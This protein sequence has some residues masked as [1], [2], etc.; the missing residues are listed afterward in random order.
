MI[1][2]ET[3]VDEIVESLKDNLNNDQYKDHTLMLY[4]IVKNL[5]LMKRIHKRKNFGRISVKFSNNITSKHNTL[6]MESISIT[7]NRGDLV[8]LVDNIPIKITQNE[9]NETMKLISL[10]YK[11][12]TKNFTLPYVKSLSIAIRYHDQM[13]NN[14]ELGILFSMFDFS[15]GHSLYNDDISF[16][17]LIF[18]DNS[19]GIGLHSILISKFKLINEPNYI[20]KLIE[21]I[22]SVI[23]HN[24]L[25]NYE[26]FLLCLCQLN[27]KCIEG[28]F[29]HYGKNIESSYNKILSLFRDHSFMKDQVKSI[30]SIVYINMILVNRCEEY[31]N[32]LMKINPSQYNLVLFMNRYLTVG[33][34]KFNEE[35]GIKDKVL[36]I[37]KLIKL[38]DMYGSYFNGDFSNYEKYIKTKCNVLGYSGDI[39]SHCYKLHNKATRIKISRIRNFKNKFGDLGD[40]DINDIRLCPYVISFRTGD[41]DEFQGYN[42]E[43]V[44]DLLEVFGK[45]N[46]DIPL[47]INDETGEVLFAK[48]CRSNFIK[49]IKYYKVPLV[50]E[51][52]KLL[53]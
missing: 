46:S 11:E 42:L 6:T 31:K 3:L 17:D 34:A 9:F 21:D 30:N 23:D 41:D 49:V 33:L 26:K 1:I 50:D 18:S 20:F 32:C 7:N 16:G 39:I 52:L 10:T 25:P 29:N 19:F 36:S 37:N 27:S 35:L 4:D 44:K 43:N 47:T 53:N 51:I 24:L 5:Y 40:K 8:Y 45:N 22:S 48:Y 12:Y 2:L 28:I 38:Y 14:F 15:S 13:M